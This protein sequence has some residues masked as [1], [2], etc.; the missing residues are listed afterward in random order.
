MPPPYACSPSIAAHKALIMRRSGSGAAIGSRPQHA[1]GAPHSRLA[2]IVVAAAPEN[3]SPASDM[4]TKGLAR[5]ET[6]QSPADTEAGPLLR[7]D[8][9]SPEPA[10]R[11][12]KR[13]SSRRRPTFQGLELS[14]EL[15]AISMGKRSLSTTHRPYLTSAPS[16][17]APAWTC[18]T[19]QGE[20]VPALP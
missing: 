13:H 17:S 11:L 5:F 10:E 6:E 1:S 12:Q 7:P 18:A 2:R 19:R 9:H 15:V 4:A 3:G 16:I 14:P 20:S 8:E